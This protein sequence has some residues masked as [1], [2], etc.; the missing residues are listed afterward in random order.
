MTKLPY[1]VV[2]ML[3]V[4]GRLSRLEELSI[5]SFL[6][7]GHPVHLYTYDID[8]VAPNGTLLIDARSVL[9]ESHLFRNKTA[10]GKGSW[11]SFS[12]W[13]RFQLLFEKGGMWADTDIVCL[14]PV[15][16]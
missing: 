1:P 8:I 9:D 4:R 15:D 11:G 16:F 5:V 14:K 10:I 6:S 2:S 7:N 13:F 3:W 12:D